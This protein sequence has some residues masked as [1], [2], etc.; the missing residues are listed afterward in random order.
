[1][2]RFSL[3]TRLEG[4]FLARSFAFTPHLWAHRKNVMTRD[5]YAGFAERYDLFHGEFG[6]HNPAEIGFFAELFARHQ[7]QT[8]LDCACG[9]GRHLHLLHLLGCQVS[10]SDLSPSM[11]EQARLNLAELGLEIPLSQADYRELPRHHDQT[12]DAVVCLSSSILHMPDD[13][14][15]LRA[16]RSMRGVLR[17]HGILVLTQGTTDRQ[18]QEKP[19]F[20]VAT[21]TPSFTR[22]FVIDYE[23]EGARY[24]IVDLYHSEERNELQT[25]SVTYTRILLRDDQERLLTAAGFAR[26]D[27][28]GSFGFE[29]Y[30]KRTSRRLIAVAQNP[31]GSDPSG[32]PSPG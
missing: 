23:G 2:V 12:F 18:W 4:C 24:N 19:R 29:P 22:V 6:Q 3:G 14:Q 13:E 31:A 30:D 20:L 10:G 27:F 28:Y 25:W 9:T 8:V 17:P 32:P 11:L 21:N 7:V 15:A 26:V 1:M 16:L 5:P